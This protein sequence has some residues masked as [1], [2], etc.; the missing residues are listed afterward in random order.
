MEKIYVF[1][2]LVFSIIFVSSCSSEK[3]E[4]KT[5]EDDMVEETDSV[6]IEVNEEKEGPVF[7]YKTGENSALR[8]P[9]IYL[10]LTGD[11]V[12]IAG[13]GFAKFKG[14]VTGEFSIALIEMGGKCEVVSCG[15]VVGKYVIEEISSN[16]VKLSIYDQ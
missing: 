16:Y 10:T 6:S 8:P 14:S 7:T 5:E 3:V 15:D 11:P 4:V 12:Q 1:A 2:F 9:E 13:R